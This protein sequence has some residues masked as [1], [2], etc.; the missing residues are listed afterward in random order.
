MSITRRHLIETLGVS[1]LLSPWADAESFQ[2]STAPV[3]GTANLLF[4]GFFFFEFQDNN[5]IVASPAFVPHKLSSRNHGDPK[6]T[7]WNG[8]IDDT[9]LQQGSIKDIPPKMLRVARQDLNIP[10]GRFFLE[11]SAQPR[12]SCF[13]K[14]PFPKA[15]LPLRRGNIDDFHKRDGKVARSIDTARKGEKEVAL[16]VCLQYDSGAAFTRSYYIEHDHHPDPHEINVALASA[17]LLSPS[18]DL[19]VKEPDPSSP[20]PVGLD[21]PKDLPPGVAPDDERGLTELNGT[22]A[23]SVDPATCPILGFRP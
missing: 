16:V 23:V 4:H 18:F 7:S 6:P 10:V 2:N 21:N 15:F 22:R 5:L 13:V 9:G 3:A 14:L 1:A 12:C 11:A 17:Q 8:Q 20:K 19:T